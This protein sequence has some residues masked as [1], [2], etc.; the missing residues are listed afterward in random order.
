[1][2]ER[3]RCLTYQK[4][5]IKN[6]KSKI[7]NLLFFYEPDSAGFEGAGVADF[8][9]LLMALSPLESCQHHG[10]ISMRI[11]LWHRMQT[12]HCIHLDLA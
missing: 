6:Q 10:L 4:S 7:K 5:K 1:V 11:Y 9:L 3:P 2:G 12:M 8:F